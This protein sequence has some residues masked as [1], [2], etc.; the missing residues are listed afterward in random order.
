MS[1]ELVE[2]LAKDVGGT[3]EEIGVL[4][5]NSGFATMSMPLPKDHWLYTLGGEEYLRPPMPM[6]LGTDHPRHREIVAMVRAAA[7]YGICAA[8]DNGK[9]EDF[10]PDAMVSNIVVGL[11]GYFTPDGLDSQDDWANPDPIP[12]RFDI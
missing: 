6:R 5:D 7:Q 1:K 10:D 3:I 9:I 12:E 2:K 4:P 11:L 8:T